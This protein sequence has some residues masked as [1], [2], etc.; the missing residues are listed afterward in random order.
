MRARRAAFPGLRHA[1]RDVDRHGARG[2]RRGRRG[3]ARWLPCSCDALPF[4]TTRSW[5][6]K[7]LTGSEKAI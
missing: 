5:S 3:V 4:P 1:D 7:P 2:R 6:W